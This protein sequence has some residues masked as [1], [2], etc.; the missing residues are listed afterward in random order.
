MRGQELAPRG[1]RRGFPTLNERQ[2]VEA[3]QHAGSRPDNKLP[4]KR[5]GV[6]CRD[7]AAPGLFHFAA[8]RPLQAQVPGLVQ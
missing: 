2:L 7:L 1:S 3:A 5:P 4:L 8:V 6:W